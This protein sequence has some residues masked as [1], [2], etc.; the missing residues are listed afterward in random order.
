M[1]VPGRRHR[2]AAAVLT[3]FSILMRLAQSWR[4]VTAGDRYRRPASEF[5]AK[6]AKRITVIGLAGLYDEAVRESAAQ[7]LGNRQVVDAYP[8]LPE[9]SEN[10]PVPAV[11]RCRRGSGGI[12]ASR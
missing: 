2:R 7:D 10:D 11:R 9:L 1:Y 6:R 4:S 8:V 3:F 5:S 12:N